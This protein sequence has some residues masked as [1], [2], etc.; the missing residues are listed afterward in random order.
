MT[1]EGILFPVPSEAV[2]PFGG[3]LAWLGRLNLF[4]VI[5]AGTL[6]N[7]TGSLIV[8]YVCSREGRPFLKKY[9]MHI[10]ISE[11]QL[12]ITDRWFASYGDVAILLAKVL[13]GIRG[14][15]SIPA[16]ISR[17]PLASFTAFTTLGV[18][19]WVSALALFGFNLRREWVGID[20]FTDLLMLYIHPL[21][22]VAAGI[23]LGAIV[24]LQVVRKIRCRKSHL[25]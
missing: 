17:M 19:V 12:D 1:L 9:G 11:K 21:L 7:V 23:L 5:G 15:I 8:Y 20:K 10:Y 18:L 3:Y 2:I 22:Y 6:G 13:P 16:G 24:L 14:I 25:S 4:G